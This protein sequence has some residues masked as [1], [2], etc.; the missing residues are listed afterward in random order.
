M[1]I[2]R[3]AYILFARLLAI[4]C[5][6]ISKVLTLEYYD[7]NST[8]E[9]TSLFQLTAMTGLSLHTTKLRSSPVH[10]KILLVFHTLLPK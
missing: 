10:Q 5:I 1:V 2:T 6:K 7:L 8:E 9:K 4:V 3:L